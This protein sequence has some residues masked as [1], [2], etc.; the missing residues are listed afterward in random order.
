MM[1]YGIFWI[2]SGLKGLWLFLH[3]KNAPCLAAARE[4]LRKFGG[5]DFSSMSNL[6]DKL[7][8][9][10]W[11]RRHR[12]FSIPGPVS[13]LKSLFLFESAELR[14]LVLTPVEF[15]ICRERGGYRGLEVTY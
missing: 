11:A 7:L 15:V 13:K 3:C 2:E 8:H 1:M 9:S 4:T 6:V 14:E 10:H 5:L 12:L